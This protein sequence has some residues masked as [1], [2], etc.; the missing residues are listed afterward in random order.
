MVIIQLDT[1]RYG[2]RRQG[3][4]TVIYGKKWTIRKGKRIVE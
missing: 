1:V 4:N 2:K 3:G